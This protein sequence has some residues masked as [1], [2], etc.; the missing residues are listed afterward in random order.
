MLTKS[1]FSG[2]LSH[3]VNEDRPLPLF[4]ALRNHRLRHLQ[5]EGW[6]YSLVT[7]LLWL[8]MLGSGLGCYSLL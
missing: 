5:G 1:R 3:N 2:R 4:S 7:S 8:I 6:I